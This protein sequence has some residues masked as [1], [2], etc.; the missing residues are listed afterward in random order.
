MT[1]MKNN[2]RS[3]ASK[4]T[5]SKFSTEVE[6]ILG[7]TFGSFGV[8]TR[9]KAATLGQQTLQV[10]S[11]STP[12][13]GST[14]PK[15]SS[16]SANAL[17]GGSSVAE[18]IKKTLA[19]LEQSGS[20]K[21]TTKESYDSTNE[22][23]PRA[24]RN[25]SPLKINL[26]D[27][28]CY[29]PTSPMI[30]QTM[31]AAASSSEKQLANLTKL[32]EG[33]TKHVQHQESRI[34]KLMD[35]MEGLLD[36]EA[37]HAPGKCAEVQEIGDPA[38][39]AP[40]V[41]EMSVS[42]EGMIPLDRLKE[43]IEGTIKDKY[44]VSTKSS[45][46]YAKPY[47][48]RIDNLKMPA[49]YQPPKFQQFEGRGNPKQHVAHFVETCN[50]A[51]TYG[52]YLVK[53]FVRSLKGNAFD[54]YTD[55]EPN[56]IDSW[57]QLEHEFLNRFYSTRR[58]VSMVELTNTRQR[59]D[60]PAIDFI[61]RWRNASLNCKDRLSEASA[62]E[63]C[64][65]GMHWELLYILQGIKPKSFE[66]LATRA[67]DME[68]S[69]SSAGK[70]MTYVRDPRKG[71]DKQ[72]P[73]RWSKFVPRNDNKESMNVNA[74]P[75]KITTDEGVKQNVRT[76]FQARS[77]QKSTLREMQGKKYPFLDSDVSEIFD[78][79]L[80]L[81]LID[82]PEMKRPD[83]AGKVDDPNYCKYHRLVSHPLEKC[84]VFK[85]RVMRLVNEK[86]IVL[87]DEKASSNQISITFGSLD[88]VQIYIS[89]NHEE[90]SLEQEVNIDGDEGWILVTR[91][92]RNKSSLRKEPSKPPIRGKMVK[93][94]EK[95]K[96][97]K[98][99]KR[100]KVEVHHYQ[101]PR[102]PVTLEEFLPSSFDI[103]STRDNVEASCFNADKAETMKV[104][105]TDKEGTTSE[106]SSKVSPNNDEKT[107]REISSMMS[108]SPS[109]T[110]IEPS[111]QEAHACDTKI[112]FTD[113]DLLFGETLHNRPLY[114]AGHVL[115]KKINRIL[116]DEG[117]GVNILPIH[118]LKE[119][120][121]TTGELSESRLLIQGFN[122]GGQRSIGSI[123]LEIHMEDLRS[124]AWMHV[125]DAKT[126]YNIL[127]GRPWVHENRI[128]SSSYYQCLKYL[129]DGIE[130][131]IVADDN[132]FTEVETH[133]ADA[134]F[135]LKSYVVKG[136]KS[137]DVNP[138]M[139]GKVISKRIDE[140]I[141]NVK[142][143]TKEPC[144]NLNEGKIVFSKKKLTSGLCYVPKV[145]KEEDQSS[146]LQEN[147]LRGLTLPVRRI[148]AINLLPKLQG[149]SIAQNQVRDMTLPTIRTREGFD[150]NAY[151]LFVKAG[152][153]PNEPSML[154]KLPSEDT[155]RQAR[156]GLGY[157]QPPPIRISI[158]RASNNHI[159]FE[160]DVATPNKKPFVFDRL[161]ESP[162]R[163]SVFE[164]LGPLK[165]NKN[166]RS[167]LKV[168]T[169]ASH[170]IRKDFK[171]LIPSRMR[172]RV[173]LVVSC[174]E[175]L[176]AK[177][178]TVVYTKEREED[179]ESVGSSNH[180]TIQN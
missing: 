156:E 163:T 155:T 76:V 130:K 136:A 78:E 98:R 57:E 126:S 42:T 66:D 6:G 14:T 47:T 93:K 31:V 158:R 27:N 4:A 108:L 60:E 45:H 10:S 17:E 177:A 77:N 24:S 58:T 147:A 39:K 116:I 117:S 87:D 65:Q 89:E 86:K 1:S 103:K 15:K 90:E 142:I 5:S 127:L 109:E 105:P 111:S 141:G 85:D 150:P 115:E 175:E 131:K 139:S 36:G 99:P 34:D 174:K 138:I 113:N 88:P 121:I 132:P 41:N 114:M 49:G 104:P 70:D 37:S 179:E 119:L 18:K 168:T 55:L 154:G 122:Q 161:G 151:K 8:V 135:Y 95:Q 3:T 100:A 120:G 30:M 71:S 79:L 69:M 54:W 167:Y 16:S 149:K 26:R 152:Y 21:S 144:P 162:A 23:P 61:N 171:S 2:S 128:V 33:L 29:S 172:R 75:A 20:K 129:E 123:K 22:S 94:L 51:G 91:R 102:R 64:I 106:S 148:D 133:F 170:L 137:N 157:S 173:E 53:Q 176:K 52:D 82:L 97:I 40:I 134:K 35:R 72:E 9:N 112:T 110:P 7:V 11:T 32:V 46:M 124:S 28:P 145:K 19:L 140:A 43:F 80:E 68:L 12:V 13:F 74:S 165:K 107:T 44:E 178:H 50:N 59:K 180:V 164:R 101:N 81:K 67:H 62:I 25:V 38:K 143:D 96:S 73:K 160:D 153:N 63:M 159:T 48:A 146:N 118:T 125:I 84:F 83:E 56:S 169:P 92:R 166:M